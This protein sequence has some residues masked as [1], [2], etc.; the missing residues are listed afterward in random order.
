[1][2]LVGLL[3]E[4]SRRY[5]EMIEAL[6]AEDIEYTSLDFDAPVPADVSV[7]VTTERERDKVLFERVVIDDDPSEAVANIRRQINGG[8]AVNGLTIGIDPGHRP[9]VAAVADGIVLTRGVAKSPEDVKVVIDGILREFPSPNVVIRIGNGD[10][11]NRNRTFNDLWERGHRLEIV[12][13][14][15]TTTRSA[16]PDE[17]AAVEIALTPGF[18][19]EGK[20]KVEPAPGEIRNIQRLSRLQS[21][22]SLTVSKELASKVAKG[23]I[24]MDQA[25]SL[26]RDHGAWAR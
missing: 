15:N 7:V 6:K 14:R 1:M 17:D 20:Q 5:Y 26:Q 3:T 10:R 22:G 19:P 23:E 2:K 12:D 11:T 25:I 9:G 8:R 4:D 16:T 13:E 21:D 24:S 18:R